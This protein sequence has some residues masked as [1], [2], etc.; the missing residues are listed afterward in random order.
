MAADLDDQIAA[1]RAFNR[2]YT[3]AVGLL[4]RYLG[5]GWSLTEARILY[6]LFSRDGLSASDLCDELGLDAGYL[7]RI[8]RRFEADGLLGRQP[9]PQDGRRSLLSLTPAGRAAFAPFDR[10]SRDE[11]GAM[12]ARLASGD[13]ARL[14]AAMGS[15]RDLLAGEGPGVVIRRHRPGDIGAIVAGQARIYTRDYGWNDEFEALVAEI[16]AAFLKDNDPARERAF[17]ADRA[18]EVVGSV[19]CV[20]GGEGIAKLRML[21]V[22]PSERGTGLGRR[23]VRDCIAF[24]R[25]AGYAGMTL[26]TNDCLAAARGIYI[27]EGFVLAAE[28]KHHSFGVDLIGQNW[29]LDF[30][31]D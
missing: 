28:E 9:A 8:L 20:D 4:G 22:D 18:G 12:L 23:L 10:A 6:E 5:A 7:S 15:V 1:I 27:D 16:G 3:R 19:F 14:V 2:F 26:W 17:I 25:E 31:R 11:I 24:A 21:Y 13:R 29:T 30:G